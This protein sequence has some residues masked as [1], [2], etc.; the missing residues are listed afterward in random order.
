M[1]IFIKSKSNPAVKKELA[2]SPQP[3]P[4]PA[5]KPTLVEK[6]VG[7]V[8]L[9]WGISKKPLQSTAQSSKQA[10]VAEAMHMEMVKTLQDAGFEGF[11]GV[12]DSFIVPPEDE[13]TQ[14][15]KD[16]L[17]AVG[18]APAK[19]VTPKPQPKVFHP[20][21][22]KVPVSSYK[23]IFRPGTKVKISYSIFDW[24]EIYQVGDTGVVL[25]DWPTVMP[26]AIPLSEKERYH[27]Y[28][29]QLDT[30]RK[31]GKE[32]VLVRSW[33]LEALKEE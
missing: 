15:Q 16:A 32:K 2:P 13:L 9:K 11:E 10:V 14:R 29:I 22:P 18:L 3:V 8:T 7:K 5:P 6:L 19:K 26:E 25:R 4:K 20:V 24:V 28:E 31:A 17:E 1:P 27:L 23:G 12:Q 33:E 21:E 30:P